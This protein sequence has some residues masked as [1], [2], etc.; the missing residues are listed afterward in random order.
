MSEGFDEEDAYFALLRCDDDPQQAIA[1]LVAEEAEEGSDT[2][3]GRATSQSCSACRVQGQEVQR[4]RDGKFYC[5]ACWNAWERA[6][7]DA[8]EDEIMSV[9]LSMS[10]V[11]AGGFS[12]PASRSHGGAE[13]SSL[14]VAALTASSSAQNVTRWSER[15]WRTTPASVSLSNEFD[16]EHT[17]EQAELVVGSETR[18]RRWGNRVVGSALS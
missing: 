4:G 6:E 13:V 8:N 5:R 17:A 16:Q 10:L 15:R 18:Q 14:V 12:R 2:G 3:H 11:D 7:F 1:L 9:A